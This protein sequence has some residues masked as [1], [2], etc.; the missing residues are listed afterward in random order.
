[1]GTWQR[2]VAGFNK[3]DPAF[4]TKAIPREQNSLGR[5]TDWRVLL[6][7][8]LTPE[9]K[10]TWPLVRAYTLPTTPRAI[11]KENNRKQSSLFV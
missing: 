6:L 2:T 10:V 7:T 11:G 3:P 1:M 4:L 9:A 8:F 5:V